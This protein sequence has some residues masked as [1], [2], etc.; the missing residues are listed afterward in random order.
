M[1]PFALMEPVMLGNKSGFATLVKKEVPNVTV[2]HCVLHHHALATKTQP[3]ELKTVL[4][5]V[6]RAVNFVRGRAVNHRLLYLFV[7]KLELSRVFFF[8]TQK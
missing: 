5:V 8:T 2:T 6:V 1:V 4:S 7:K 3:E